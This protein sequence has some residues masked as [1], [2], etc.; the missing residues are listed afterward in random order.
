MS[1]KEYGDQGY[2]AYPVQVLL[3]FRVAAVACGNLHTALAT[4]TGKLFVSGD[5]SGGRLGLGDD[6]LRKTIYNFEQVRALDRHVITQVSCGTTHTVV[7]T[8]VEGYKRTD[9]HS[10]IRC[11]CVRARV[12][13]VRPCSRA[14]LSAGDPSADSTA[15]A[16]R[17]T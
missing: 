5:G 3:P 16:A 13:N 12:P 15:I 7:A 10:A 8:K 11:P 1:D 6:F 2:V 17:P 9:K 14:K 4:T